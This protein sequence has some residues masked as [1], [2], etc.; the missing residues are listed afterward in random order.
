MEGVHF[1]E[2]CA[3]SSALVEADVF[4]AILLV[5]GEAERHF[6]PT[7]FKTVSK[8]TNFALEGSCPPSGVYTAVVETQNYVSALSIQHARQHQIRSVLR[9][10][11]HQIDCTLVKAV[12]FIQRHARGIVSRNFSSDNGSY[13]GHAPPPLLYCSERIDIRDE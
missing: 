3:R 12:I 10:V 11:A 8:V 4:E 7:Q 9:N 5:L 2:T 1:E 6:S 13:N